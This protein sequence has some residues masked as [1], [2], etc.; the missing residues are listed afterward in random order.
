MLYLPG[1]AI[2]SVQIEGVRHQFSTL[3]G[4]SEDIIEFILNLKK[5]RIKM[6]GTQQAKLGL[7]ERGPK[8]IKAKDIKTPAGVE[9]ANPELVL[10]H[11]ANSKSKMAA[12]MICQKGEGYQPVEEMEKMPIGVIPVDALF[13]PV[14]KVN[15]NISLTR[16]GRV[17]NYEKLTLGIHTDDTISPADA[18]KSTARILVEKLKIL[19]EPP[20]VVKEESIAD[21]V[22]KIPDEIL[23]TTW[24]EL[25][26]PTR[27]VNALKKKNIIT[28]ENFLKTP[29]T[30]RMRIKNYG[31]KTETVFLEKLKSLGV[32]IE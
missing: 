29:K 1:A 6:V 22:T 18:L 16:V 28:V 10:A 13:S 32:I 25:D 23:K 9:I 12:K 19:Y 2:T 20:E 4:M 17:T 26:L 5:V 24:E 21:A 3:T 14:Q 7:S 11:L 30:T 15:F 8:V 31:S 27:Y